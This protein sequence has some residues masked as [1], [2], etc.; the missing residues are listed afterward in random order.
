[1]KGAKSGQFY[2]LLD[3]S[4]PKHKSAHLGVELRLGGDHY[5]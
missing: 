5:S 4:T 3:T 2:V 1:M